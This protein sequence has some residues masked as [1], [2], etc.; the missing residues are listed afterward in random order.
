MASDSSGT[1]TSERE[2]RSR[3]R[4]ASEA[5]L[6]DAAWAVL[7]RDGVLSGVNLRDVADAASVNRALIYRYFGSRDALLRAALRRRNE[8]S[9][10]EF[11][12]GRQ[13]PFAE[14]REH[15]WTVVTRDH[16]YGR[17]LALLALADDDEFRTMPFIDDTRRALAHDQE[18]GALPTD[19]DAPVAHALTVATY[20]GYSVLREVFARELDI[21]I[22]E[23]D[24]RAE[25]TFS[26]FV[27]AIAAAPPAS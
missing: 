15:A 20:I 6:L 11:A 12:A 13:L 22:A 5:E 24:Q 23:L 8:E 10:A 21:P 3:D 2:R 9:G 17:V 1:S 26:R 18:T 4:D 16:M 14:R 7:E 27:R 25:R 19:V